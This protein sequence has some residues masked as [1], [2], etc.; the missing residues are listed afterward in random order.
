MWLKTCCHFG[1][2]IR[3]ISDVGVSVHW[4]WVFD[5]NISD[6]ILVVSIHLQW[7]SHVSRLIKKINQ[8]F[9]VLSSSLF[10]IW[11]AS[12]IFKG[13]FD[14]MSG[15][16]DGARSSRRVLKYLN[17]HSSAAKNPKQ[18]RN[19]PVGWRGIIYYEYYSHGLTA[20]VYWHYSLIGRTSWS[21]LC[22]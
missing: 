17:K 10:T 5:W 19:L 18:Q 22:N 16:E 7:Y 4:L 14:I 15:L 13:R 9:M 3:A 11:F 8:F 2:Y 20:I 12:Q 1:C 21:I 6:P